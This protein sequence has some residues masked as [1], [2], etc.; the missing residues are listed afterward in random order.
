MT[1]T[2]DT[3]LR[4][5]SDSDV[6][7]LRKTAE[8]LQSRRIALSALLNEDQLENLLIEKDEV[9][10]QRDAATDPRTAAAL[11]Q[12]LASIEQRLVYLQ[13]AV[14]AARR[15]E[16]S[17][18]ALVHQVEGLRL[19]LL[20]AAIANTETPDL[21]FELTRVREELDASHEIEESLAMAR[22][23]KASKRRI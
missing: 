14:D 22:L 11:E 1:A 3:E 15:L 20:Q 19:S 6:Q 23:A 17:E 4:L 5:T 13:G 10:R 18:R 7:A 8:N 2:T 16:A 12:Q 9:H 21:S